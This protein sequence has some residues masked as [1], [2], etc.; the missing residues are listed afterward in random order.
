MQK[1]SST[2]SLYAE[3]IEEEDFLPNLP[4]RQHPGG[5]HDQDKQQ[6]QASRNENNP[7]PVSSSTTRLRAFAE[8]VRGAFLAHELILPERRELKLHATLVNTIYARPRGRRARARKLPH[9]RGGGAKEKGKGKGDKHV[10][11]A[12]DSGQAEEAEEGGEEEEEEEGK[13]ARPAATMM[14]KKGRIDA[15]ALIE[16]WADRV[17]GVVD[18]ERIVICEMGAQVDERDGEVRYKEVAEKGIF[19]FA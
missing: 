13:D 6:R 3:P 5:S 17:W 18:V 11:V 2:S 1:P 12:S 9:G 8:T 15:R 19:F 4:P 10:S 7:P 16:E 14:D